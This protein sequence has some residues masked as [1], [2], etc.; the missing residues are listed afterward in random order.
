ME[1]SEV[2]VPHDG[3][4]IVTNITDTQEQVIVVNTVS[5]ESVNE[6]I[7]KH[8]ELTSVN[9]ISTIKTNS[10]GSITNDKSKET[11]INKEA[12]TE[13]KESVVKQPEPKVQVKKRKVLDKEES[14]ISEKK[15]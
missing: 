10:K 2:N 9:S 14:K 12:P 13:I 4:S 6:E 5:P 1:I 15:S 3:D 7:N 8:A 11:S